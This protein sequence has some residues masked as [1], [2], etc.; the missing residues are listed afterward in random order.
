MSQ[1]ADAQSADRIP[2]AQDSVQI[3][4]VFA[5]DVREALRRYGD[6]LFLP[7]PVSRSR[8]QMSVADRAAQFLPF[9]AVTGYGDR[10]DTAAQEVEDSY[11]PDHFYDPG[12][13]PA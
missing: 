13:D 2:G 3:P 8:P 5:A 1:N 6:I 4:E 7:H 11:R 12:T 9:A 10:L